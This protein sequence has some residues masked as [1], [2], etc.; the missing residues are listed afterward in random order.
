MRHNF[1][2]AIKLTLKWEGVVLTD[3]PDD[4]G[5]LTIYGISKNAYPDE[6][7]VN[8]TIDRAIELYK[9]D[10]WD[11]CRCDDLPEGV[12]IFV[13]DMSVNHGV[14]RAS[15]TLQYA[16]GATQDGIIGSKTVAATNNLHP[17]DVIEKLAAG[18]S[19]HYMKAVTKGNNIKFAKGWANRLMNVKRAAVDHSL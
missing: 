8:L 3:D 11:K 4:H 12:D 18:R 2:D 5:G 17:R 13:F 14:Y 6:D 9:Q 15:K 16:V 7:I 1:N 10:Y 19:Y